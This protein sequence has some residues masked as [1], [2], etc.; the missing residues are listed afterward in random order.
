MT[1]F[2]K[3]NEIK[4]DTESLFNLLN[5]YQELILDKIQATNHKHHEKLKQQVESWRGDSGGW[6]KLGGMNLPA[7]WFDHNPDL[8]L[9]ERNK[10]LDPLLRLSSRIYHLQNTLFDLL[11]PDE[12][13]L[14]KFKSDVLKLPN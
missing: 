10:E 11:D 6:G 5:D 1:I 4:V 14:E 7:D 3:C 13:I 2:E 9:S 12:Q 8:K